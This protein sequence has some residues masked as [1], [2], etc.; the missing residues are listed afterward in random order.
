MHNVITAASTDSHSTT[1]WGFALGITL[2]LIG[3]FAIGLIIAAIVSIASSNTLAVGGK[4]VWILLIF[5]FPL[6]GAI[7]WFIWGRSGKFTKTP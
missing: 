1:E 2:G 3:I 7:V 5:A 4:A 6:L